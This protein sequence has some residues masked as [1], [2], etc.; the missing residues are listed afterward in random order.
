[1]KFETKLYKL[2]EL[3]VQRYPHDIYPELMYKLDRPYC[4]LV[5][6][7]K[8]NFSICIPF[9]SNIKHKNAYMFKKTRRSRNSKSGLDYTKI[10]LIND[11]H[12]L[13]CRNVVVDNDEYQETI[14]NI[15]EIAEDAMKYVDGYVCYVTKPKITHEREF[16]RKYQYSTL[17]YFH[18]I[19][20]IEDT[21]AKNT[22]GL[23]F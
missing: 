12:Y 4:C 20:G 2:T 14:K 8:Y 7:T 10:I 17:K 21:Y 1:M 6:R 16:I 18:D 3:F 13:D 11:D 22:N 9:R 5:I 19:M 23:V 15:E